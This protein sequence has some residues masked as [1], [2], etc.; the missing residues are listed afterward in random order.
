MELGKRDIFADTTVGLRRFARNATFFGVDVDQLLDGRA[1]VASRLMADLATGLADGTFH[2]LPYLLFPADAVDDALATLH[3]SRHIGKVVVVQS[4]PPTNI[5]RP[6]AAKATA[7]P[8]TPRGDGVYLITG[9]LS[10]LGLATARRFALRGAR[11][12]ALAGRRGREAP[13]AAD[14]VAELEAL[15]A[16][17]TVHALDVGDRGAVAALIDGL[18]RPDRPLAGIVHAAGVLDDGLVADLT[19]DRLDRVLRGK[20]AGAWALHHATK[21]RALDLF[22]LYSS[23]AV[24]IGNVGQANYAAANGFLDGLAALRRAEGRHGLSIA[25]G[26]IGDTGFLSHDP[27]LRDVVQRRMGGALLSGDEAMDWLER[28]IAE[29][30]THRAVAPADWRLMAEAGSL[31]RANPFRGL[32]GDAAETTGDRLP[33][34]ELARSLKDEDLK[35][36]IAD[37]VVAEVAKA[38]LEDEAGI[39]RSR[40]TMDLGFDS[41]L[42]VEL[43]LAVERRLGARVPPSVFANGP[44]IEDLSARLLALLRSR[45]GEEA[46][47]DA[48]SAVMREASAFAEDDAQSV[49]SD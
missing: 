46:E 7:P 27:R 4:P 1:A 44:S 24:T 23:L 12:L 39:D 43:A 40:S 31:V 5:G 42:L 30:A 29:D 9:G 18:D 35:T 48:S 6:P 45:G 14:A 3:R 17:V 20:A 47:E 15:G 32:V 16:A 19:A 13:G 37:M 36:V 33:I 11:H 21:G 25:W 34:A 10:G 38:T 49:G 41:L 22:V 2:P 26:G 8:L 28:L